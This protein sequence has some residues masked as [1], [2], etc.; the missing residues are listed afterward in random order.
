MCGLGGGGLGGTVIGQLE[1]REDRVILGIDGLHGLGVAAV[2]GVVQH[3]EAAKLFFQFV[4]GGAGG[5]VFHEKFLLDF[6][7]QGG[8]NNNAP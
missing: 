8:Y 6:I 7:G 2:V 1:G 5:E 3:G 4:K